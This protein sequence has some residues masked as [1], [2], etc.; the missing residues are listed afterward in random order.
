M[1]YNKIVLQCSTS[2][3]KINNVVLQVLQDIY[4]NVILLKIINHGEL[5]ISNYLIFNIYNIFNVKV[6]DK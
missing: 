3:I 6:Q 2:L 1:K 5:M 4:F